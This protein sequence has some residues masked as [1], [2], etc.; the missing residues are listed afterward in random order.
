MSSLPEECKEERT[1]YVSTILDAY[2][3]GTI[4]QAL[5]TKEILGA[6]GS[7]RFLDYLREQWTWRGWFEGAFHVTSLGKFGFIK[8]IIGGFPNR[9]RGWWVFRRFAKHN[10]PLCRKDPWN[11]K[12]FNG[13]FLQKHITAG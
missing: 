13:S 10:L 4:V 6:F 7:V 1:I 2:N 3:Y 9:F 5:A 8:R 11:G 12:E